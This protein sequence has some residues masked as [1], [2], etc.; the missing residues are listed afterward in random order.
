MLCAKCGKENRDQAAFCAACGAALEQSV[1]QMS[2]QLSPL[3]QKTE[4]MALTSLILGVLAFFTCGLTSIPGIIVGIL[5]LRKIGRS[6]GQSGGQALAIVG[7]VLSGFT[8][9]YIPIMAAILFPVFAKSREKA[10][11]TACLSNIKQIS[12]CLIMY[13]NDWD[14]RLPPPERWSEA[15]LPYLRDRKLLACPSV[16]KLSCGYAL[17]RALGGDVFPKLQRPPEVVLLFESD[18]GWNAAGGPE[19]LVE[20]PR[21]AGGENFAYADGH[22]R[23]VKEEDISRL[24]WAEP[25]ERK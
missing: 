21:H 17:N 15:V 7:L 13:S 11:Q 20:E 9:L 23:W 25:P 24:E 10:R 18:R 14:E 6:G 16:P 3:A 19:A 4:G 12:L 2:G 22:C 1:G 8:L 5:A